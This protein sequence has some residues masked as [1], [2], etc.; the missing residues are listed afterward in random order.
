MC[1]RLAV[2]SQTGPRFTFSSIEKRL[3]EFAR[4]EEIEGKVNNLIMFGSINL[5]VSKRMKMD[6]AWHIVNDCRISF[7]FSPILRQ[8]IA[9]KMALFNPL[10][11]LIL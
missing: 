2:Y 4:E 5:V 7:F 3:N 8:K 1:R 10:F 11:D 6:N 9:F